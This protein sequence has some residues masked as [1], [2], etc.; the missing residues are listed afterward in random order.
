MKTKTKAVK[1]S[2]KRAV[3]ATPH[4]VVPLKERRLNFGNKWDFAPAPED[5]KNYVIAPQHELFINGKFV[6]PTSGKYFESINPATEQTL[7]TI[8]AANAADV[9]GAVKAA[10]KAYDKVWSKMPGRERGKYLYRIARIIQEKSRELAV[11]ETMDGGKTIKESRDVDLPLVAAHFFYYAGWADKLKYAFPGKTPQPLGVAGQIIP[12]NFPLLMAAWKI[13]PALACG[14][15]VVLKPAETTSLTALRLAQIFQEAELPDGVVNIVT[16]AGET[17]AALV[18]HP[19]IDKIAFT[20]STD[21]GKLIARAIAARSAGGP[22]PAAAT[23]ATDGSTYQMRLAV[24]TRCGRE[25][26]AL[27]AHA[28]TRRQGGEHFVRGRA[29]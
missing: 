21:V 19:D 4:A 27:L 5:S 1:L 15:T 13:A 18:N 23:T 7:T 16:G 28:R 12:W 11:L 3:A 6:K 2:A 8:A 10:R 17:G 22:S 14:N 29:D 9:D 20:G 26:S 25:P 24:R